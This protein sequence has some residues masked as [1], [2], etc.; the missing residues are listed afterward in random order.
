[1]WHI[2]LFLLI[3][4]SDLTLYCLTFFNILDNFICIYELTIQQQHLVDCIKCWYGSNNTVIHTADALNSQHVYFMCDCKNCHF[5]HQ[6][7]E[8]NLFVNNHNDHA[9]VTS[10]SLIPLSV[11]HVELVKVWMDHQCYSWKNMFIDIKCALSHLLGW[12]Q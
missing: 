9:D 2:K 1:M 12:L 3:N 10:K 6:I 8:S 4:V 5:C 11:L 7:L